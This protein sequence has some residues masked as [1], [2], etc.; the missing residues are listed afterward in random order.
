MMRVTTLYAATAA[1]TAGYYTRYL[2]EATGEL[3][4][5]WLGTQAD[6][7]GLHGKVSTE[8]LQVLLSGCDPATG[9]TL[10]QPLVDRVL[11][12]GKVI[13][14][15]SGFDATLSAPKSLSVLWVL[16]GDDGLAKCHDLAV[17]AVADH[18]ERHGATTRV[19]SNGSRMHLDTHGLTMAAFRQTTS[20][21][22]DPQLHTHLVV[23][24]KVQLPD[25]RWMA[26]DARF[27]KR[28]QR[29]LGGLY[30]SVLRA[31]LT[32]RYGLTFGPLVNGQAEIAGVSAELL[33][34]F[35][36][37]AAE[38]DTAMEDV[39]TEF[40]RREGCEP[41]RQ[42][43]AA[44]QRKVAADSRGHKSGRTADDL[45]A[46][47][48]SGASTIGVTP[49]SLRESVGAAAAEHPPAR[50]HLTVATIVDALEAG[51][52]TWHRA[53]VM[54]TICDLA[55]PAPGV[56]G[57]R[58]AAWLDRAVDTVMARCVDLDPT[59]PEHTPR[60]ASDG[61]SIWIEPT[62]SHATSEAVLAQ[63]QQILDWAADAMA[64]DP[65]P[66][67]VVERGNLDVVQHAAAAAVA[68][69][70]PL[71][72][73]VGP[74]GTGK[75]TM[76]RAAVATLHS[77]P[78]RAV[79]GFAPTAK[80][81][82]V[83]EDE[84]GMVC[85]TVAKLLHEWSRPDRPP[86]DWWRYGPHTTVIVDEAGM[87]S[88]HDLH[89]LMQLARQEAW[90]LVLVGDP[91]QLQAV[92]RGG[93]FAELCAVGRTIE[94]ERVHRFVEQ[95]EAAA[96]LRLRQGDARAIDAY[97]AHDRVL[98]GSLGEHADT[99]AAHWIECSDR[100]ESLAI[101]ATR[102]EHVDMINHR[103]QHARRERGDLGQGRRATTADGLGAW[104]GDV[105]ATRRND[106]TLTTS[107]GQFVRNRDQWIVT[108]IN[109]QGDI[110]ADR[111]DGGGTVVVPAEYA[112]E[113]VRLGYAATEPGNQSDTQD[114]SVT[115]VTA[116]TS[117][118]GMYVG[119][120]RGRHTN[121]VLVVTESHDLAEARDVLE[122]AM[123]RNTVDI[124]AV[125]RRVQ[126]VDDFAQLQPSLSPPHRPE[127]AEPR[128]AASAWGIGIH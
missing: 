9:E 2:T 124:P 126:L 64:F 38:I 44:M 111:I 47:W 6:R 56:S 45:R 53:D 89:R 33:A 18:L 72:L 35:S 40:A 16:T 66:S 52:S 84:T 57:E 77:P 14:A 1:T 20:R 11:S 82:R 75:T 81:A 23:S 27:L 113:H 12:N 31:E 92:G 122:Q 125:A 100:G 26:L 37:R 3:P 87:L 29:M 19:R 94:L 43:I 10:G 106:R 55:P 119:M 98:A 103:I 96:S 117:G 108:G 99:I 114:Q 127:P 67:A 49:A 65:Q 60:R 58:W 78:H 48:L 54:R 109:E 101:T 93:M 91:H 90:R 74:A 73:I 59:P 80:A 46:R 63:E 5:E 83:L 50:D 51:A 105:I 115:L 95:W 69:H 68:G 70:D 88:T 102:N 86:G 61:R 42:Q 97:E 32:H 112:R 71:T 17:R 7:L 4:G 34:M 24:A 41:T 8:E 25:D 118:R 13:R 22:D 39:L 110:T 28:H 21:A 62:A 104:V 116:S 76:L 36:K 123:N 121:H 79:L 85:D 120:T 128:T 15:V 107:T 30:Q